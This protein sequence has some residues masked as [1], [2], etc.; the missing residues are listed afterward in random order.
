MNELHARFRLQ[1]LP[2][3][4]SCTPNGCFRIMTRKPPIGFVC[5]NDTSLIQ[6][7]DNDRN[8]ADVKDLTKA[9]LS[10]LHCLKSTFQHGQQ[11]DMKNEDDYIYDAGSAKK[12][13]FANKIIHNIQAIRSNCSI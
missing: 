12:A 11:D 13:A 1:G 7:C 8:R 9:L 3:F 4:K 2:Q 5:I 6:R 10:F